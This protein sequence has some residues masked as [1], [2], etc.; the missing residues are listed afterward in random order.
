MTGP[1]PFSSAS[2]SLLCLL[3][4]E[5]PPVTWAMFIIRLKPEMNGRDRLGCVASFVYS[6]S[7]VVTKLN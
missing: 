3:G 5:L 7:S 6:E 4:K 2:S 1:A